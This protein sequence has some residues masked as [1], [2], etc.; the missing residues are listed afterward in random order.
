VI[1][2]HSTWWDGFLIYQ[3]NRQI[4]KKDFYAMMLETQLN[5]LWFL[6]KVGC[7]SINPGSKSVVESLKFGSDLLAKKQNMV[8]FYPQG[9]FFSL[10]DENWS[11]NKGLDF[12][13]KNQTETE[14]VFYSLFTDFGSNEKPYL[15]VYLEKVTDPQTYNYLQLELAYKKFYQES[16]L[17]H[18]AHFKP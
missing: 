13:L 3:L 17:K 11:F 16:K 4:I 7:F 12:M 15:N 5:E 18:I 1:G 6:Q 10:F 9:R 8:L 2:N 14:I